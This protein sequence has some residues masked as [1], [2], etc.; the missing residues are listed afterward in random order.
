MMA[1][2]NFAGTSRTSLFD[3]AAE[4]LSKELHSRLEWLVARKGDIQ[5]LQELSEHLVARGWQARPDVKVLPYSGSVSLCLFVSV[6]STQQYAELLHHFNT[7]CI[8]VARNTAHDV[9]RDSG[10]DLLLSPNIKIVLHIATFPPVAKGV[11]A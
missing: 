10:Y 7:E 11:P 3:A 1:D 9:G 8:E 2:L 4:A 5:R 6:G